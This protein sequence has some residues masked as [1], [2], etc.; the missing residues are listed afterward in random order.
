MKKIL[1]LLTFFLFFVSLF[2]CSDTTS[3]KTSLSLNTSSNTTSSNK[4][5]NSI[6]NSTTLNTTKSSSTTKSTLPSNVINLENGILEAENYI[7]IVDCKTETTS[8]IGGGKNIGYITANSVLTYFVYF[9]ETSYYK[10]GYRIAGDGSGN[11]GKILKMYLDEDVVSSPTLVKTGGWQSWATISD[12]AYINKGVYELKLMSSGEGYNLNKVTFKPITEEQYEKR[13]DIPVSN[14][15]VIKENAV[16]V[17]S[18]STENSQNQAWYTQEF[19]ISNK[20]KRIGTLNLT[21]ISDALTETVTIDINQKHQT[22]LGIGTSVEESS[23]NNYIGLDEVTR[24]EVL[25]TLIDPVNGCGMTLF[26]LTIGT[27]DF[28]SKD[29]YTYYDTLTTQEPDWENGFS[30]QKDIDYKII[31][32][33]KE[34]IEI[35][36]ELGVNDE[37]KFF[38]SPWTPP[39]WMKNETSSSKSYANNELL[40]KGGSFNTEY[41]DEYAMYL[42]RYLEEYAKLGIDIYGLTLQNEPQLEID[43]PSCRMTGYQEGQIA[44]RLKNLIKESE[45]LKNKDLEPKIFVFDHNPSDASSFLQ[46]LYSIKDINDYIDGI[47]FHDYSGDLS[48]MQQM[49]DRFLNENQDVMLTERSVWGTS[50]AISIINYF[51]NGAVSY[52]AWVTMLDSNV[53]VHQWVGT[54]SPTLFIRK[55]GSQDKYWATP[56]VYIMAQFGRFIRPGYVRVTSDN[57]VDG[58]LP[59]VCFLDEANNKLIMVAVNA[60][61]TD[62]YFKAV[63]GDKEFLAKIAG[64]NVATFIIDLN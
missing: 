40:L 21:E 26:R 32:I 49:K 19:A 23:V 14:A 15:K 47:A 50:G 2:G 48:I 62:S 52:N 18:T 17:Y 8:D 59:N 35:A 33:I 55:A 13:N 51:R 29:F 60:S 12:Y 20:A 42:L 11:L 31:E 27:S 56:E 34:I 22:F 1:L 28:T 5:S 37:I 25:K 30:I 16:T 46:S 39:G 3:K 64:S 58:T 4:T 43:Y 57:G 36:E 24:R 54:P 41:Y 53:G 44:I 61:S 63:I 9:P 7:T 45:I 38:S 6:T 10:I